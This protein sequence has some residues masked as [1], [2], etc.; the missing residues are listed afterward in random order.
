MVNGGSQEFQKNGWHGMYD[1][2][3]TYNIDRIYSLDL[4]FELLRTHAERAANDWLKQRQW[5]NQDW[6]ADME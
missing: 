4:G 5:F 3:A 1:V 2:S 6:R